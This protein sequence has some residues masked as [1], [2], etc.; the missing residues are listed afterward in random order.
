MCSDYSYSG[1]FGIGE[2]LREQPQ[3]GEQ[4]STPQNQ[5]SFVAPGTPQGKKIEKI[6]KNPLFKDSANAGRLAIALACN[7]FFGSDIL[8]R[9]SLGGSH[10]KY[11][12]LEEGKLVEIEAIVVKL[13][14]HKDPD[15]LWTKCREAIGKKCQ[16]LRKRSGWSGTD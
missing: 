11:R 13:Y 14:R 8:A 12:T 2:D 16:A 15:V 6:L 3:P 4:P 5:N 10:G 9:S 1:K 7:V